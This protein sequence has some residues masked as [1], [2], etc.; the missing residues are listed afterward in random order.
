MEPQTPWVVQEGPEYWD[1]S[2]RN[3]K[4]HAQTDRVNLRM[5]PHYYNQS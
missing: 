5:L 2:T 3:I 1:G 4:A